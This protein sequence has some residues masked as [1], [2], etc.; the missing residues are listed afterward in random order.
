MRHVSIA[1]GIILIFKRAFYMRVSF[2]QKNF[3][4]ITKSK[5]IAYVYLDFN[6]EKIERIFLT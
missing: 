3:V 2:L 6:L 5:L 4:K 1:I